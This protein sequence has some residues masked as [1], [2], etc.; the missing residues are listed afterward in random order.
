MAKRK[1]ELEEPLVDLGEVSGQA[2]DFFEDNQ[3]LIL[4]VVGA[5]VVVFLGFFAYQNFIKAPKE[6]EAVSQ[7]HKAQFLF[8]RDSFAQ[9]L[10]DPGGGF[11]GLIDVADQYGGTKAGNL[12]HYYAGVSFLQLG[13]FDKAIKYLEEYSAKEPM[14]K[15]TKNGMLGDA[16]SELKQF[17]KA[18]KYYKSAASA[19]GDDATAPYY[20]KKAGM[21]LEK[22][23]KTKEAL[24]VYETI[25][26]DYYNTEIGRSIEKYIARA[27]AQG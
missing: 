18:V 22:Q 6:A 10:Q 9:A 12:A 16:Y 4:G 27:K 8:E 11:P 14:T 1:D 23:G 3:S 26:D 21:L 17:D 5:L 2:K 13:N 25:R 19:N 24:K 20:L 15:A 7:I